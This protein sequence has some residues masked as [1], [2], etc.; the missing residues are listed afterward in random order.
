MNQK[1]FYQSK[2]LWL[3][4]LMAIVAFIPPAHEFITSNPEVVSLGFVVINMFLRLVTKDEL[5]IT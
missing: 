5:Q 3:N 2:T 4:L 1:P